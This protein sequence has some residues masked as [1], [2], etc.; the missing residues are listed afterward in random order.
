MDLVHRGRHF[1]AN[2][3]A[4][5]NADAVPVPFQT[6]PPAPGPGAATQR[7]VARVLPPVIVFRI[8]NVT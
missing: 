7:V 8:P 1:V 2:A 5:A 6:P 3:N 4:N